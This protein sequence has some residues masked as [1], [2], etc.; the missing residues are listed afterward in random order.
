MKNLRKIIKITLLLIALTIVIYIFRTNFMNFIQSIIYSFDRT[1][2]EENR[3][4]LL[5]NGLNATLIISIVSILFGTLLGAFI[6]Y[7]QRKKTSFISKI[8]KG[9]IN[10]MQGIPITVLLLM[11]YYII[12]G[13]ININPL[14]VCIIAFSVYFS[15]YASEI[16][17][18]A[19][20]SINKSQVESAY[21][22]GFSK[23]Q[24]FRYIILPQALTYIIPAY[25]NEIVSLIKL[26]SIAG[27]ISVMDLTKASDIIRNRTYEA[28]FPLI[29]AALIYFIIC[30]IIGKLL[31]YIYIKINPRVA[32]LKKKGD[33]DVKSI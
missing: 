30:Y 3:Y 17:R 2:I 14:F 28:F 8:L 10:I 12:F 16:F 26:T 19:M 22:L 11:F 31:D 23:F 13:Q 27:Y 15:A 32:K 5:L 24:T 1:V 4:M 25:K 20:D 29:L 18:G 7:L 9:Y 33:K 21:S 6:C